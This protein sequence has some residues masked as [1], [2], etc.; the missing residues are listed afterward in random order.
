MRFL[1]PFFKFTEQIV[2][3]FSFSQKLKT[4]S[5]PFFYEQLFRIL[6]LSELVTDIDDYCL[7]SLFPLVC[8]LKIVF[9]LLFPS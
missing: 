2:P 7:V 1:N 8:L 9:L 3:V 4:T 6:G 5:A